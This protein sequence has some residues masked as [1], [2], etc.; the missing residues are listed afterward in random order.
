MTRPTFAQIHLDALTHNLQR[1]RHYAPASRIMAVIK[2]DAYGH[3]VIAAATALADADAFALAT[4]EEACQLRD[5]EI[6]KPLV[7]LQGVND[8]EDVRLAAKAGLE[9]VVHSGYQAELLKRW[10]TTQPLKLWLKIDTGM[11]RLGLSPGEFVALYPKLKVL[12]FVKSLRAMTHFASAD[13][14]DSEQTRQQLICFDAAVD[15]LQIAQ[16]LANSAAIIHAP[17]TRRDW[18]RP[19]IMLYG[20]SPFAQLNA[21]Q[22]GLQAVM[23]LVSRVVA[24]RDLS[25]GESVGY[26]GRFVTRRPSRI[27]VAAIGYGDG[28]PRHLPDGTPVLINGKNATLAGRVSMD[29]ITIDVTDLESSVVVGD[30]VVLWGPG[31]P[32]ESIADLAGTINYELLTG[33][34][35]RVPRLYS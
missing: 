33:V 27:A 19:G 6:D 17:K 4:I 10:P 31:L 28:Y 35:P 1:V 12:P 26:G 5:A 2:A 29:S 22:F 18:V 24:I 13:E 7:V 32:V 34:S 16:S 9:L 23:E 20:A 14:T 11:H 30:K 15:K 25:A 21:G 8:D 3:G